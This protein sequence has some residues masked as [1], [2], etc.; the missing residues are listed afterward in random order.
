[1]NFLKVN[2]V[3]TCFLV[4]SVVTGAC[5]EFEPLGPPQPALGGSGGT[6]GDAGEENVGGTGGV[7]IDGEVPTC[8]EEN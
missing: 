3:V 8:L 1:M 6:G 5:E 2:T 4:A 7:L